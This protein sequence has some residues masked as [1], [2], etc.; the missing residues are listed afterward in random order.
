MQLSALFS[1]RTGLAVFSGFLSILIFPNWNVEILA[2]IVFLPLLVA[3]EDESLHR[4]FWT[5]WIAGFIHFAGTLYWVTVTMVLYGGLSQFFSAA[6]LV[7]LAMYLAIY[8]GLFCLLLRH[9]Q[10]QTSFP[11]IVTAPVLWVALEYVRSFFFI[12]FPWNLLGY[13]QFQTPYITQIADVTGVYGVSFL[14]VF[15]NAGIYTIVLSKASRTSKVKAAIA[16]VGIL[17][18]CV[19]YSMKQLQAYSLDQQE[20]ITVAVIQ[21]NIAQEL[22]WNRQHRQQIFDTYARLSTGTLTQN[23]HMIVWPETAIPFIFQYEDLPFTFHDE[24]HYKEQL[25]QLVQNLN[26]P[27][28]FGGL[29]IVA[30][31]PPEQYYTLNSAFLLSPEGK[32][33]S[34]YD[35]IHLVPFGEYVPFEKLLFFV[36]RL[37]TA[38]G[39]VHP[40]TTYEIMSFNDI[41]FGTV[42]CFEV[43]FPNLVRK[44]VDK[45]ARFLTTITNDAWFGKTAASYQHFAM[46]TFRAIENRVA[47]ARAANT[48][49]SGFIDPCG[50]ILAESDIFVEAA[51][52]HELPLRTTTTLYTRYGD[53]FAKLCLGLALAGIGYGFVKNRKTLRRG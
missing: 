24:P 33:L 25:L 44:F 19:G 21:G 6:M 40:G 11:L 35:K 47:F 39:K 23:P 9:F 29:D 18:L 30:V 37:T 13:C 50:R 31:P 42:I 53:W 8:L 32:I 51:L 3:I 28:L 52:I 45:G 43:I 12:G 27:L 22:K 7:L 26:V 17:G 5:G 14:I 15:V 20:R 1:R 4:T 34:K 2:W 41:P 38:I 49:I 36:N 16:F 10:Q 48:G 46:V